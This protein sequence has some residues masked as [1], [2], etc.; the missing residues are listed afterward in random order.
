MGSDPLRVASI[1]LFVQAKRLDVLARV[2]ARDI[3]KL[4]QSIPKDAQGAF[5]TTASFDSNCRAAAEDRA[6]PR[7]GLVDGVALIDLLQELMSKLMEQRQETLRDI[8][9]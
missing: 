6:F 5:F 3:L 7:I 8:F 4:L 9:K 2:P 1:R